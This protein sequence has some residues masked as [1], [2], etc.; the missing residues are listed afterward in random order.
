MNGGHEILTHIEMLLFVQ[1]SLLSNHS[2]QQ[3]PKH[4]NATIP[5]PTHIFVQD[6]S[7]KTIQEIAQV[8]VEGTMKLVNATHIFLAFMMGLLLTKIV[9]ATTNG[10]TSDTSFSVTESESFIPTTVRIPD[11]TTCPTGQVPTYTNPKGGQIDCGASKASTG[12][13]PVPFLAVAFVG[14]VTFRVFEA[15]V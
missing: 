6:Q 4:P 12:G 9:R 13:I 14:H 10:E 11:S 5:N 1:S 3:T 2:Q 7:K 15:V 8:L